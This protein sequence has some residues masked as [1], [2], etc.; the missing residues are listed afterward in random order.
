MTAY[1]ASKSALN[2]FSEALMQEV[3]YENIRVTYIMPGSV[4]TAAPT[5]RQR[6]QPGRPE[7]ASRGMKPTRRTSWG[8]PVV[9][10]AF[11]RSISARLSFE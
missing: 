9:P 1:C 10:P 8:Q 5:C 11:S 7:M 3:R 2:A 6:H 4:A